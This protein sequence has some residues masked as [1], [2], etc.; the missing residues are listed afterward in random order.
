MGAIS[1]IPNVYGRMGGV[2]VVSLDSLR[3]MCLVLEPGKAY[4]RPFICKG[5]LSKVEY[6]LWG[7]TQRL[8]YSLSIWN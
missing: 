6:S 7:L 5:D 3:E 4:Y 8:Q 2:P 1:F